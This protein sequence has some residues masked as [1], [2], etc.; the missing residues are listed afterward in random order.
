MDESRFIYAFKQGNGSG[1]DQLHLEDLGGRKTGGGE[2]APLLEYEE[3]FLFSRK[4]RKYT[5]LF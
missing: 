5:L 3:P 1:E 4:G 2:I